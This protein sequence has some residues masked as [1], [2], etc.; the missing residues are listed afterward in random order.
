MEESL[1]HTPHSWPHKQLL[2]SMHEN[3]GIEC[4]KSN[5]EFYRWKQVNNHVSIYSSAT[6]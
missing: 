2:Y 5:E 4:Y 3:K 1:H 6:A